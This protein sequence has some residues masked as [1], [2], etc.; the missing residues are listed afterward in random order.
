MKTTDICCFYSIFHFLI[1][2]LF[3]TLLI[4]IYC[5]FLIYYFVLLSCSWPQLSKINQDFSIQIPKDSLNKKPLH[6]MLIADTHLLSNRKG[7]WFQKI[8]REWQ[9]YRSF[10]SAQFLFEP[11]IIFFLGDLTDDGKWCTNDEWNK[12]IEHFNSLFS[13]SINTRLYVIPGNRDIGFHYEITDNHIKRFEQTF[14]TPHVQLVTI[15]DDNIE[16]ILINSMAF[17]GDQCRLCERADNELNEIL[18]ELSQK[19]ILT[20]PVLLTHFPLYRMSDVNCSRSSVSSLLKVKL[21]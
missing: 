16:F 3:L 18:N 14:H 11:D 1:K 4:F 19:L 10:Q 2:I 6:V 8:H 7:Y 13:I 5:E 17:E 12:T 9:M 15:E 20:K 21:D